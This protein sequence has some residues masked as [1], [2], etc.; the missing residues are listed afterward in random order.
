MTESDW[1]TTCARRLMSVAVGDHGMRLSALEA[2]NI[3]RWIESVCGTDF[4]EDEIPPH[5][6]AMALAGETHLLS[7]GRALS[8]AETWR[9][10]HLVHPNCDPA[11]S[12]PD[13]PPLPPGAERGF[14][15][16]R[17]HP[18]LVSVGDLPSATEAK[19]VAVRAL[20][21]QWEQHSVELGQMR[22]PDSNRGWGRNEYLRRS[23]TAAIY[24]DVT[25]ALREILDGA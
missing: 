4:V 7:S 8:W 11:Y 22:R 13:Q 20:V 24:G 9:I 15:T 23:Q 21:E 18:E 17:T 5:A 25:R 3:A 14:V 1:V 6:I 2:T 12:I 10:T 16:A 19:L